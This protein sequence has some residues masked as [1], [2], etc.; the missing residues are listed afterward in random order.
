MGKRTSYAAGAFSWVDLAI[1]DAAA[2]K[3]LYAGLCGWEMEDSDAG[4]GAVYTMCRV[5]GDAVCGL[6][7]MSEDMRATGARPTWTSYVTVADADAAAARANELGGGVI[8][9]AFEVLDA[10]RMAVL[11]DPQGAVFAVWQPRTR[12]GA[13]RVNDVGCLCMNELATSDIDAARSFYEGL[14]GW[15]TEA[16][17][18]PRA[19]PWRCCSTARP[20]MDAS[21][22]CRQA[23]LRIGA[24][25]SPSSRPTRLWS[26]CASLAGG[27]SSSRWISATGA[28]RWRTTRRAPSS[29]SLPGRSTRDRP[30][31]ALSLRVRTTQLHLGGLLYE[32]HAA[33]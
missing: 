11:R 16:V 14:F 19:A 3:S 21:S 6:F 25:A 1:T 9:D 8:D 4:D 18:M 26:G 30:P 22:R 5:D 32:A 12:I 28:S 24:R 13:E 10:G 17:E 23:R 2:A 7:E 33:S 27:S 15:T 29:R 31:G 20:S